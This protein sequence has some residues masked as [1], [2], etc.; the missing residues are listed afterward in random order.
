M[1]PSP[2]LISTAPRAFG[3]KSTTFGNKMPTTF[4]T[5]RRCEFCISIFSLSFSPLT[6]TNFYPP[7]FEPISPQIELVVS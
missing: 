3:M 6:H 1:A 7:S 4:N 2:V 5:N